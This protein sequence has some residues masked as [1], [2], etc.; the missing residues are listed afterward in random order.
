[1]SVQVRGFFTLTPA[2]YEPSEAISGT[3]GSTLIL[4]ETGRAWISG[5]EP[6]QVIELPGQPYQLIALSSD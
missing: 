2:T 4:W 1:M 6:L 3:L 5:S